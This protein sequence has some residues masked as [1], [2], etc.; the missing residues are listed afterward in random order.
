MHLILDW[1]ECIRGCCRS[2]FF[3]RFFQIKWWKKKKTIS[4][5]SR[6]CRCELSRSVIL[7]QYMH[8]TIRYQI[9][10]TILTKCITYLRYLGCSTPFSWRM[11]DSF[12][13]NWS[14]T[15]I[16]CGFLLLHYFYERP[17][18]ISLTWSRQLCRTQRKL[19]KARITY[20]TLKKG[21]ESVVW[22]SWDI[23]FLPAIW[24]ILNTFKGW[25]IIIKRYQFKS[26]KSITVT[27]VTTF[28]I[29]RCYNMGKKIR[30]K[31]H[32]L[33]RNP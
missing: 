7:K 5:S 29:T 14:Q 24:M 19:K 13:L 30:P 4:F 22:Y 31:T 9:Q 26:K 1:N 27:Y 12:P 21:V 18:F 25:S 6:N 33:R 16:Q 10:E 3:R 32:I 23:L 8:T 2:V 20:K 15:Q 11:A 17:Y 28:K